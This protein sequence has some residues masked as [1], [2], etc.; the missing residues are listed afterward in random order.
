[1][2]RLLAAHMLVPC[3][4]QGNWERKTPAWERHPAES[5][6]CWDTA[7]CTAQPHFAA[8]W[9]DPWGDTYLCPENCFPPPLPSCY[10]LGSLLPLWEMK[11]VSQVSPSLTP[12]LCAEG[13]GFYTESLYQDSLCKNAILQHTSGPS[14][15]LP[16][17]DR[18]GTRL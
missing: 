14:S 2:C 12:G 9:R 10:S 18:A 4:S 1:M 11:M 15:L 16:G 13:W 8:V 17:T 3:W 5:C 6:C 7:A